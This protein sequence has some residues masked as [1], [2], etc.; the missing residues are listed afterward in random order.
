MVKYIGAYYDYWFSVNEIY[1]RW[2][3]SRGL[4]STALFILYVINEAGGCDQSSI[5]GRLLLPKQ[6]V[7][8]V[9]NILE[10]Q[11]YVV[12]NHGV[13]DKR[14]K[15]VTFT[16]AGSDY[17]SKILSDLYSFE[18]KAFSAM[19]GKERDALIK[20]NRIFLERLQKSFK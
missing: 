1:D 11:G 20:Y 5:C 3:K 4:T 14:N 10:K 2:A 17:A 8:S 7:S 6:T 9:L 13:D 12:R 16:D 18:E 19:S 15:I